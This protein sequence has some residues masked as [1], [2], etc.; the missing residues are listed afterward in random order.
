MWGDVVDFSDKHSGSNTISLTD[1]TG[2]LNTVS[3]KYAIADNE[4]SEAINIE[5]DNIGGYVRSRNGTGNSVVS[6]DDDIRAV[7]RHNLSG[8]VRSR[9]GTG[10]SVVSFDDDLS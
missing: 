6:F 7:Y 5:F 3:P 8:Y 1:F 4:L 10:N 9:N 2:G